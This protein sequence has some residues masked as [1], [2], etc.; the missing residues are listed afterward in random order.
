MNFGGDIGVR[1]RKNAD[2]HAA[3]GRRADA[4]EFSG[5]QRAQKFGLQ[6]HRNVGD[7]IEEE[8]AGIRELESSHAVS[9]CVCVSA[10][11]VAEKLAFEN[12]LRQAAGVHGN[13]RP[14]GARRKC[15]QRARDDV[16]AGAMLAHDQH[17]RVRRPDAR[18]QIHHR[19]HRGRLGDHRRAAFGAQQAI[20]CFEALAAFER[21]RKLDLRFQDGQQPRVLPGL[22]N[23]I[24]RAAAHRFDRQLEAAPRRHH[25]DRHGAIFRADARKQ[26]ESFLP[27]SCIARVVEIDE[28]RIE[29]ARLERRQH[30]SGRR[31]GFGVDPFGF[32]Q[33]AQSF[34]DVGLIIGDENSDS[35]I[36]SMKHSR[37]V[38]PIGSILSGA[39]PGL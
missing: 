25:D 15:M 24:F 39:F 32:Q 10:L 7:F 27:G 23:E 38:F 29:L 12:S 1:R 22:L 31:S 21:L 36:L 34:T 33:Q 6:I 19:P 13:E 2:I 37:F 16:F 11:H 14:A 4:L 30:R 35:I 3:S 20:F 5:F 28:Q 9:F 8:R 17:V 26:I 18:N